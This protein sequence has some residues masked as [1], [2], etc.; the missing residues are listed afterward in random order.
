MFSAI[1]KR[2]NMNWD[3]CLYIKIFIVG[4]RPCCT[5]VEVSKGEISANFSSNHSS[6]WGAYVNVP[7]WSEN[8][9]VF[10]CVATGMLLYRDGLRNWT[11]IKCDENIHVQL[12]FIS[13]FLLL[14]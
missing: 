6:F 14:Y 2:A 11:V 9:T 3:A 1:V 10:R 8:Y 5:M 13:L 4:T 12:C 7:S